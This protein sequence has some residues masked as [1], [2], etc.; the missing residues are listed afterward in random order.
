MKIFIF[1]L[2]IRDTNDVQI[3]LVVWVKL[4]QNQSDKR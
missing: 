1:F 2:S 4:K 3:V